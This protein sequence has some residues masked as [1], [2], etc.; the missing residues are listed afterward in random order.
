MTDFGTDLANF[1]RLIESIERPPEPRRSGK[2]APEGHLLGA[3]RNE[4]CQE[5]PQMSLP[6][7]LDM[8]YYIKC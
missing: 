4:T 3:L 1:A 5:I 7:A 8:Q 2:N 6:V